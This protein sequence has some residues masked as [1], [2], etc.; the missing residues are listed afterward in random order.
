V[1]ILDNVVHAAGASSTGDSDDESAVARPDDA[2]TAPK[3]DQLVLLEAISR[4]LASRLTEKESLT[5]LQTRPTVR[6]ALSWSG[7]EA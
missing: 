2:S 5:V 6:Q 4:G 1:P 3:R 7:N